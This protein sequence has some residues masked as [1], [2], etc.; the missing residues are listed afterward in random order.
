MKLHRLS[1]IA[2]T[3]IVLASAPAGP[4]HRGDFPGYGFIPKEDTGALRFLH[5]HPEHDGRG[6]V[7]AIFDTG[8]DPGAP[9]LQVTSDGKPKIIDMVDGGGSGDVDT[10]T[11][12]TPENGVITGLS[13]RTLKIN[14]E[15][16]NPTGA[17]HLGLKRAYEI[18]PSGL[19]SR[20]KAKRREK[21]DERQRAAVTQL[22]RALTAWDAAHPQ[23]TK[24]QIKER[25]ELDARLAQLN[26]LREDYDDP[27][28]VFDCVVFH[29]GDAWRAAIDTDEDGDLAD[30]KA[31][32]NFRVE[33]E[34]ATFGS[35]DLLNF[36]VNIYD[37]GNLLSIVTDVGAHGTHVAGIV[38]AY[39]PDQPELNGLAPGAQIV[40][41][42][43]GDNRLDSN[44]CATGEVRGCIAVLQ[45][46][47]DLINQSYGEPSADPDVGRNSEIYSETVNEHGVIFVSSAGNEGPALST[48]GYP[49]SS[50]EAILGVGA[51]VSP[52]MMAVQYAMRERLPANQYTWSTRG[53]S[54]D[55]A[56]AVNFSAPGGAIA[57]VPNWV[58][59]RNMQMHGTSMSSPNACGN[60]ALLLSALKAEG[61]PYSPHSIRRALENTA[62][63]VPGV[64][65]FA[66][67]R[68]LIQ[69]DRAYEYLRRFHGYADDAVRFDVRV[70]GRDKARG[71]YLRE[72]F[73]TDRP[74]ETRVTVTPIFPKD[75]DNRAKVDFE[76]RIALECT[77]DWISCAEHLLLMHGGRRMTVEVDPTRLR[78]GVHYAEI[79]GYDSTVPERGPLFRL[80]VT[81]IKPQ[82]LDPECTWQ[83]EL[84][85]EPGHIERRFLA[86]PRGA[87]W[88]D[89]RVQ[90]LDE[91]EPRILDLHA[92]E[93]VPGR[94]YVDYQLQQYFRLAGLGDAVYS[95]PVVGG[96][97]LEVCLAQYWASLGQCECRIEATFHGIAPDR[98]VI[99]LHGGNVATRMHVTSPLRRERVK[100]VASLDTLRRT[101]RPKTAEIRP[102]D[103][104]RDKLPEERQIYELVLTYEFSLE[105]A[106]R[107]TP[108]VAM[109]DIEEYQEGWQ[110]LQ[111]MI[112]DSAKR[113]VERWGLVA[114]PVRLE[115]GDY[116]LR[117]HVRHDDLAQ[118]EK[119]EDMALLLDRALK[120]PV[121]IQFYT[122]PDDALA[123]GR[124]FGAR[125]LARGETA[126][127]WVTGPGPD[128][129]PKSA[130]P[131]DVLLGTATFGSGE[132][133]EYG[134]GKRPGGYHVMYVVPPKP[135]AKKEKAAADKDTDERSAEEQLAEAIRDLKVAQLAKLRAEEDRQL[136][137]RIAAEVLR[138]YPDHLPV[139]VARL[140]RADGKQREDDLEAVVAAADAVIAAIDQ[141]ALAAHYGVKLDPDDKQAAKVRK[142]MDERKAALIEALHRK[143]KALFDIAVRTHPDGRPESDADAAA[144]ERFD[145][146]F[147]ALEKW[148]DTNEDD[149]LMLHIDR[150]A[151][152]GRLGE[153]LELLSEKIA[154]SEP[155]KKLQDKRIEL[156]DRLGWTHW[157][158]YEAQWNRIRFPKEYPPL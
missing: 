87:T 12:V 134:A 132:A 7:V 21:F 91:G 67:G 122:D 140:E 111:Y 41:V 76:L 108:R 118:L 61:I 75:A 19:V 139:L 55:G 135:I 54:Y 15:W 104:Y 133:G 103:G 98:N 97:T 62:Q 141:D 8:V 153:A 128:D 99:G 89:F 81:V 146:A 43:I 92:L 120:S 152:R 117:Y 105:K 22:E 86:V 114:R 25:D 154:D 123:D 63:P 88:V 24:E 17:Y 37:E 53:P 113:L 73:E 1:V 64:E 11:I 112:F 3:S 58:L 83:D 30:E 48:V 110:S 50:T 142:E 39:F 90:R 150:A 102:L 16:N 84:T 51:Y 144:D 143:A 52:E 138:D 36:A 35:E 95:M 82:M 2:L 156:L 49:G 47:C 96:R 4:P 119:L 79:R 28:P 93:L 77:A 33:R 127:L 40:A 42:K 60:I 129:L 158:E 56:L 125:T 65:V 14:P 74:I 85:F 107:V 78:P 155:D 151:R 6:T 69:I 109:L 23:P 148:V 137:D 70:P 29:N 121:G 9:G 44:S 94:R 31:M 115:K 66:Q 26:A 71:I 13:G 80:P 157:R 106:A 68:G 116:V 131:G 10:S 59:Q 46:H 32:T 130:E 101:L 18:Y 149:Y 5:Q 34:H 147:A 57:P 45:N 20:L 124:K 100:P 27:G 38:A 145:E 72:P 126:V 136:F